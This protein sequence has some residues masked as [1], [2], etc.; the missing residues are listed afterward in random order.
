MQQPPPNLSARTRPTP[1]APR[2]LLL[3]ASIWAICLLLIGGIIFFSWKNSVPS[4]PSPEA[5]STTS[6]ALL[7]SESFESLALETKAVYVY[8]VRERKALYAKNGDMPLPLASLTKLLTAQV[9]IGTLPRDTVVTIQA[10]DLATEGESG[11]LSGEQWNLSDLVSFMLITSSNDAATALKTTYERTTGGS[12]IA[13]MNTEAKRLGLSHS[14]FTNE[15]GLDIGRA[16]SNVG[17]ASDGALLLAAA[18]RT[19]PEA[20]DVT[21][22]GSF[23]FTSRTGIVHTVTNTNNIADSIPWAVGAKTGFTDTAGGNLAVSFDASIGRPVVIVVLGSSRE[24]RFTDMGKLI[25][26]TL[27]MMQAP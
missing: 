1:P 27:S 2:N 12:F 26:A 3:G 22:Y 16:A 7:T 17:S 19:I 23:T 10:S 24:G 25:S 9:A 4:T 11:L 18:L 15:T 13:A 5:V 8:D 20:L 14:I 6:P 21:R